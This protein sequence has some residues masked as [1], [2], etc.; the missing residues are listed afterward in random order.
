MGRS[1]PAYHARVTD[2][3]PTPAPEATTV[4]QPWIP[5][6]LVRLGALGWRLLV[7]LALALVLL[8]V[9]WRIGTV[10]A[11]VAVALVVSAAMSPLVIHLR[12]RGWA[13]TRAA[14]VATLAAVSV[15]AL[16]LAVAAVVLVQYGPQLV[17]AI[18]NG[19]A[20]L[21]ER[22]DDAALPPEVGDALS[23]LAG[24]AR[25]WLAA[26]VTS[27]IG[28]LATLFSV[29]LFGTFTTFF[30]L[31]DG[32]I[33]WR[34]AM[35]AASE[36][37][38]EAVTASGLHALERV[39]G[40][41]R[42]V[43]VLAAVEAAVDFVFMVAL[44]VPLA[45]PL[46]TLVFVGGFIPYLGG[47]VATVTVLLVA[48][49]SIGPEGALVL[50]ALIVIA[51]L[52]E[53]RLIGRIARLTTVRIHP[54]VV[55]VALPVGAFVAGLF[56]LI[57]AVPIAAF[58]LAVSG[59]IAEAVRPDLEV[60]R[61]ATPDVV[62]DWFDVLAQWSWRLLVGIAL[63][64]V[65]V[66]V[67]V[68]IPTVVMPV[69]LAVV[70]ASTF[71]PLM[72][73]LLRRGWGT[74]ISAAVVTV[75]AYVG[76]GAIV[77]LTFASL[78]ANADQIAGHSSDGA[79]SVD[80][81]LEGLAGALTGLVDEIGGG[82]VGAVSSAL[83]GLLALAVVI[84]L[85]A[86]LTF[87]FLRDGG[88]A[89]AAVTRRMAP[90]RRREADA[91]G[92]RAVGVLGGYMVGTGAISAFGAATQ[93]LVM[94]ILGIPLALPLA[95][96]SFFGGFIPYIGSFVTTG[97]A[98]LV[99]VAVGDTTDIAVMAVFTIVFNIVQGN[100]VAP[101]VYGKAV[102]IHPAVVLLAIPAGSAL[103]GVVGMFLVVPFL[104]VVATTWR[105]VLV[106]MGERRMELE[107]EPEVVIEAPPVGGS[108][109]SVAQG[110][111]GG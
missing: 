58:A 64:A 10:T 79:G 111:S 85:G 18:Q 56:G 54:A 60:G 92:T 20:A 22:L 84:V 2:A 5:F 50:L 103:A 52:V 81:A 59:S 98:F 51:N 72:Q 27:M 46:A 8:L 89:W 55:L 61:D 68:Q 93:F 16:V 90:W 106:V 101:L 95:V 44:D 11:S 7:I 76:I 32:D 108:E 74:S 14:A 6:W 19:T 26:N 24:D 105:T 38:R 15:V 48:L 63:I 102:N 29:L 110:A 97:L 17:D 96:L 39:G 45:L 78:V 23:D 100:I 33:A 36:R 47:L 9:A 43:V 80:T 88:A 30:L 12:A 31:Q 3:P 75:G 21:R 86:I 34:W 99:T 104:G 70:L 42:T 25:A 83:A 13:R 41:L 82:V 62:P 4:D 49:A 77:A 69:I 94:A 65:G 35:Q 40:Y 91:A 53:D 87:F 37:R 71:A 107:P 109:S 73:S 57:L 67:V 1:R 28:Q 66:A